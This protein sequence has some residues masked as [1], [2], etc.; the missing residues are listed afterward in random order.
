MKRVL[1]YETIVCESTPG[2]NGVGAPVR[3]AQGLVIAA[4]ALSGPVDRLGTK[5]LLA[6][7]PVVMKAAADLSTA[8]GWRG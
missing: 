5:R 4:I 3:N 8:L 6:L 1:I 7:S 2:V